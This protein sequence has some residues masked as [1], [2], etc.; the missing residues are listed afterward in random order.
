MGVVYDIP[1]G[2]TRQAALPPAEEEAAV[3]LYFSQMA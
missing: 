2:N 1:G 3:A